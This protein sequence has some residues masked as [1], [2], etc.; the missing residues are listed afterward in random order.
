MTGVYLKNN[1][2]W[3]HAAT[4]FYGNSS[5]EN[6]F[7]THEIWGTPLAE[8]QTFFLGRVWQCAS[9]FFGTSISTYVCIPAL[10]TCCF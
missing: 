8:A 6:G 3:C 4:P 2:N 9:R 1:K 7:L 5:G 10:S